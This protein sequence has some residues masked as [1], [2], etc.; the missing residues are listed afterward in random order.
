MNRLKCDLKVLQN[1]VDCSKKIIK[2]LEE[3]IIDLLKSGNSAVSEMN[4]SNVAGSSTNSGNP[5]VLYRDALKNTKTDSIA[6]TNSKTNNNENF[7]GYEVKETK[8][9]ITIGSI[10][11]SENVCFKSAPKQVLIHLGEVSLNTSKQAVYEH[12]C[13]TFSRKDFDVEPCPM[14]DDA[15]SISFKIAGGHLMTR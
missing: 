8:R 13:R 5:Q 10:K 4:G 11:N 7:K 12:L 14:R 9:N 1:E 15:K 6:K 3:L 2:T